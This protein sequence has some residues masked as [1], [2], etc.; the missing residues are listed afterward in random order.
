[1]AREDIPIQVL[2]GTFETQQLVFAHLL[3]V[4]QAAGQ[5]IDLSYVDV[6]CKT[7]PGP[8]LRHVFP[9]TVTH[10][11]TDKLG[12]HTTVVLMFPEAGEAL[13][14]DGSML[15]SLGTWI[16]SRIIPGGDEA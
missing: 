4:A 12:L 13:P 2:T 10:Q 1:M 16:G 5:Q 8:R 11:L 7:D 6:I 14:I 15:T 9:E 3:D